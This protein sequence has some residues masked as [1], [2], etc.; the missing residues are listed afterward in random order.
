[1]DVRGKWPKF[2]TES[3][4]RGFCDIWDSVHA[5]SYMEYGIKLLRFLLHNAWPDIALII[6][7][8]EFS[9]HPAQP[10]YN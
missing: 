3:P 10:Y 5:Y 4:V 7:A 1:M 8:Q 9:G 2:L 6:F